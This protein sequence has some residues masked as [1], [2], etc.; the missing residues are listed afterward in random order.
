MNK[1][2][3]SQIVATIIII[4]IAIT[5]SVLIIGFSNNFFGLL[6]RDSTTLTPGYQ[7]LKISIN[8]AETGSV[9]ETIDLI[10]TR[11]DNE[12]LSLKGIRFK[13][14]DVEGNSYTYDINEPPVEAGI[15][16]SYTISN[17]DLNAET[18]SNM[19]KVSLSAITEEGKQTKILDERDV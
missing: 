9:A 11:E 13:F 17:I 5:I 14:E 4:F 16:K 3:V 12:D 15:S 10:I 6:K 7:N 2:G 8:S 18:L 1:K 19:N